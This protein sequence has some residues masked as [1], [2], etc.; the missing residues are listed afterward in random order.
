[1]GKIADAVK[2][3]EE[4]L[5]IIQEVGDVREVAVTKA[6]LGQLLWQEGALPQALL[7]IW[8]AYVS[9]SQERCLSDVEAVSAI[10]TSMKAIDSAHFNLVWK[11]VV[12]GPQPEWLDHVPPAGSGISD[13][14]LAPITN[15]IVQA[16]TEFVNAQDWQE[17]YQVLRRQ[18]ALL[19]LPQVERLFG[20]NIALASQR[21]EERFA[22]MLTIQ[23][24]LL[25]ACKQTNVEEAWAQFQAKYSLA[26]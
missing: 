4:L 6:N 7:H 20:H 23:L 11:E 15:E 12:D 3:Y 25:S 8:Q 16:V 17:T 22:S 26:E 1:Q 9:L 21:Q 19:L 18:Q 10:L 5:K 14:E 2:L 13:E 24:E